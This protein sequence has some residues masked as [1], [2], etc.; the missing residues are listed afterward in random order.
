MKRLPSCKKVT[1]QPFALPS[2]VK[3]VLSAARKAFTL[4]F[5][6]DPRSVRTVLGRA[7]CCQATRYVRKRDL[8]PFYCSILCSANQLLFRTCAKGE[9]RIAHEA[10]VTFRDSG[11]NHSKKQS[12]DCFF[13]SGIQ[14]LKF[15]LC[16]LGMKLGRSPP[17]GGGCGIRTHVRLLSNGFQDRLV[18]TASITLRNYEHL[19]V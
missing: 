6:S 9:F 18:M 12:E 8:Y 1:R 17:A 3:R 11:T 4:V 7:Y 15:E 10:H 2:C 13:D 16:R 14:T 5:S 19:S